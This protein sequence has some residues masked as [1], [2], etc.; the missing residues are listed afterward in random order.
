[1]VGGACEK[2]GCAIYSFCSPELD[3]LTAATAAAAE[4][5]FV[6]PLLK[7]DPNGTNSIV[8]FLL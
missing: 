7:K 5:L 1:M 6:S 2:A 3:C 8:H 4:F